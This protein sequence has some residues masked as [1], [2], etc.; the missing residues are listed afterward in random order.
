VHSDYQVVHHR[1]TF[2]IAIWTGA[3]TGPHKSGGNRENF[4]EVRMK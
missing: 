3:G 2:P 1:L 4:I